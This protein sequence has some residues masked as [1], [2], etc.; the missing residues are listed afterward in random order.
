MKGRTNSSARGL[1]VLRS[2][3][4]ESHRQAVGYP[5]RR[6]CLHFRRGL[7]SGSRRQQKGGVW[8]VVW[9]LLDESVL[10]I[11]AVRTHRETFSATPTTSEISLT[12]ISRSSS[13]S[14]PRTQPARSFCSKEP[15]PALPRTSVAITTTAV[16]WSSS[17]LR[18]HVVSARSRSN[19][20]ASRTTTRVDS[21]SLLTRPTDTILLMLSGD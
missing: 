12:T 3:E 9:R 1:S 6:V 2:I 10:T 15:A 4:I 21:R 18:I 17:T 7:D 13:Y 5:H 19:S 11:T 20:S 16:F 14:R 8:L